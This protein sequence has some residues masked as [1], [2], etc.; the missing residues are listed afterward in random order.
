MAAQVLASQR[1]IGWW[2]HCTAGAVF[3]MVVLGGVTRLTRSGLSMVDWKPTQ[4]WPPRS[5]EEWDAEFD[6]YKQFPEYQKINRWMDVEEFKKIYYMEFAH[7]TYGRALGVVYGLPLAYLMLTGRA[8]AAGGAKLQLQL[9]GLLGMGGAQGLVG[10]WMVKSGLQEQTIVTSEPRVS[11]YR[12]CAHLCMA[13]G[14]YSG[15]LWTGWTV[16]HPQRVAKFPATRAF[17][18][19]SLAVTGVV[20][21]TLT[22]GAFVAGNDAGRAFNDWPMYAGRW[23][24]QGI[25]NPALGVRNFL[26]NTATVQFDH[27]MLAYATLATV[28]GVWW[29]AEKQLAS[30][31]KHALVGFRAL[32]VL[33]WAQ[34]ALGIATLMTV[35]PVSLGSLH[36]AGAL[37]VW[38][39]ALYAQHCLRYVR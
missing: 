35:V 3:G 8:R 33:V 11:P 1:R 29:Q 27:R 34:A 31:G 18:L 19:A 6:K 17:K 39:V 26:E 2:L 14:L 22:S 21:T 38:T 7:R 20:C 12:L 24:P 30:S 5:P 15:L 16:M 4:G 9:L 32:G 28:T 23:V 25:W 36:Q 10:W 37:T 13:V